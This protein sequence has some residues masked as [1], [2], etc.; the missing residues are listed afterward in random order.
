MRFRRRLPEYGVAAGILHA[1]DDALL[2]I[3]G[4]TGSPLRSGH[5]GLLRR[6]TRSFNCRSRLRGANQCP[7][8]SA[9]PHG[10]T[11]SNCH[12]A[13]DVHSD[14]DSHW[15]PGADACGEP[16]AH[17]GACCHCGNIIRRCVHPR[18]AIDGIHRDSH[19]IR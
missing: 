6:A 14:A 1:P 16:K 10:G 18:C 5:G 11:R 3:L 9:H 7:R 2:G 19:C 4:N 15:H 13:P 12:N 8:A 17:S